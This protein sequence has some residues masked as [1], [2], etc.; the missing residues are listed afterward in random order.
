MR[1]SGILASLLLGIL[2]VC[3]C[4]NTKPLLPSV[5]GKAGEVVVV[6]EKPDW[7]GSLGNTT[8]DILAQDCP[9]L[10]LAEPLYTLVN[11]VPSAF[12]DLF[13]VHRNV[14]FFSVSPQTD[15]TRVVF[16]Q[17]VWSS[18]QCVIQ[19]CAKTPAQADSLFRSRQE[20]I[21]AA[22]ETAERDRVIRNSIR[23][24]EKKVSEAIAE[25][26]G[27]SPRIPTGYKLRKITDDFAWVANDAQ[28]LYKDL[29][30]YKYPVYED[31]PFSKENII[32]NRNAILKENVPGMFENT[33]MTTSEYFPVQAE[34]IKYRGRYFTQVRGMWDVQNDYMGGPFVSHSFYSPDGKEIIVAEGFVYAPGHNK[35]QHLRQVE[36]VIYSWEWK[37]N[38]E[39]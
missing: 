37:Q 17:D 24:E 15:S 20:T 11:V 8:R 7:E 35:R 5:S 4:K 23:Y 29:L 10:P 21:I 31:E 22:I 36:S 34:N 1:S 39:K 3:S 19:V 18:P 6:M 14:V 32:K 33:Y 16:R 26:F 13:K 12:G 9:F 30:I 27:G 2:A 25:V 38:E 28:S